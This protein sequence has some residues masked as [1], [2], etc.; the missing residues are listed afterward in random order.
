MRLRKSRTAVNPGV[1]GDDAGCQLIERI[2]FRIEDEVGVFR[3][4]VGRIIAD[5]SIDLA[6]HG[7]AVEP[8]R[9]PLGA[10][11]D[12]T[13]DVAGRQVS[14]I[15]ANIFARVFTGHARFGLHFLIVAAGLLLYS[16]YDQLAEIGAFAISWT[17]LATSSYVVAWIVLGAVCL[18]HLLAIHRTRL[19]LKIGVAVV[20]AAAGIAM[21]TLKL[22]EIRA[23]YGQP[24]TLRRLEPPALRLV[25]PE[26]ASAFFTDSAALRDRLDEARTEEPADGDPDTGSDD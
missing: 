2:E 24:V 5:Q 18:A 10:A 7:L 8:L 13:G 15:L 22:D 12:R 19:P 17:S 9:V 14:D 23:N 3:R 21:Q 25:A 16:V 11:L 26:R 4:P 20:L 1:G 6:A